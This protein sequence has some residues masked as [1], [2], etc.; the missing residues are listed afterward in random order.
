MTK[1]RLQPLNIFVT[2]GMF[3]LGMMAAVSTSMPAIAQDS[4]I[5]PDIVIEAEP[6][7]GPIDSVNDPRFRC[8]SDLGR[9]TVMYLPE[10]QPGEMFAWAVPQPMGGGWT[11][12]ARCDEISRRLETYRADGLLELTTGRE[13]G[14]DTVCVLTEAKS[15]CQIVFT[16][17]P[18]QDPIATRN[19]VFDNLLTADEGIQTQGVTTFAGT[20]SNND[21]LGQLQ[22]MLLGGDRP[23]AATGMN[24]RD[25]I[26]LKPFL[27][28][29]DGG[30]L[31]ESEAAPQNSST[32]RKSPFLLNPD[33]FR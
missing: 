19:S 10:S 16:V 17:P 5:P 26:N 25:G 7:S 13:N 2:T 22:G 20:S 23:V 14:Y 24:K 29:A 8:V 31:T 33:L 32:Q 15:N 12:Q 18:G 6:E 4:T 3:S 28:P 11:S 9:P 1:Q 27:D 21:I 30:T